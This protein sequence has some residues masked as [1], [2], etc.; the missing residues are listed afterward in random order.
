M[1]RLDGVSLNIA[2]GRFCYEAKRKERA[3]KS[4]KG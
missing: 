4:K 1:K 2:S 3:A